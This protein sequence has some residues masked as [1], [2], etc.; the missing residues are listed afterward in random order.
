MITIDDK[1][2]GRHIQAAREKK[3]MTQAQRLLHLI[4]PPAICLV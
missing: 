1:V 2:I 4:Y 3:H